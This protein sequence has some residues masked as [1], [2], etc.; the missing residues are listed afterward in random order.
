M[1]NIILYQPEIPPN[2][3][4]IIRTCYATNATLHIIKP[5]AFDLH[6]AMIKRAA[7]GRTVEDIQY[8]TYENY[9]EFVKQH[10]DKKIYYI[11]RYGMRNYVEPNYKNEKD[12][13]VMFGRESTGIPKEILK[14]NIDTCLRIPMAE[15]CRSLNLANSVNLVAYEILRQNDFKDLSLYEVQKGKNFLLEDDHE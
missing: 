11:S 3:G 12:I 7:A 1:I 9:D 6:H 14:N 10:G 15:K 13:W 4:N 2:T 5:M 8:F